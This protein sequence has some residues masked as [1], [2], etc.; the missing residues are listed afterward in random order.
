MR[1]SRSLGALLLLLPALAGISGPE[2]RLPQISPVVIPFELVHNR[3]HVPVE[4]NEQGPFDFMIDTM[5]SGTGRLNES[6]R[7]SLGVE[8]VGQQSNSDGMRSAPIDVVE[9]ET[10]ALGPLVR[11]NVRLLTREYSRDGMLGRDFFARDLITL[12]FASQQL[13]VETGALDRSDPRVLGYEHA[14]FVPARIGDRDVD[15]VIDTGSS[16]GLLLP[17]ELAD[18]LETT[19]LVE[20]GSARTA[21]SV[22]TLYD[23]TLLE[24]FSIAGNV[25]TNLDVT[26]SDVPWIN[27]GARVL[28]EA[29]LAL[30]LDQRSQLLR[31]RPGD[32]TVNRAELR[33]RSQRTGHSGDHDAVLTAR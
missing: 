1:P 22:L 2:R 26:F 23:A 14:F 17:L 15:V 4:V 24:P 29:G 31:L 11:S 21:N 9:V 5:A 27:L 10:L 7:A 3:V 8:V 20:A 33:S 19:D 6:L 30:T 16:L 13:R 32:E 25:L 28:A 12:D 18:S